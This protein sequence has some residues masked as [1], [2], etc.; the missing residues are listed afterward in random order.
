MVDIDSALFSIDMI[1]LFIGTDPTK[2]NTKYTIK[3]INPILNKYGSEREVETTVLVQCT[4]RRQM[5]TLD[6]EFFDIPHY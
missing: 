1:V 3:L 2:T 6:D 4:T 5:Y